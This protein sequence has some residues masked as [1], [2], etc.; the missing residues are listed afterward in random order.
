MSKQKFYQVKV[1]NEVVGYVESDGS[2]VYSPDQD[3]G[4]VGSLM[5]NDTLR[6]GSYTFSAPCKWHLTELDGQ[7]AKVGHHQFESDG[8][9][10][11]PST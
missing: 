9:E 1:N 4:S 11:V 7:G 8:V 5:G 3:K 10:F 6:T 2:L